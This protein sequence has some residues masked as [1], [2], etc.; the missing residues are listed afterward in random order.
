MSDEARRDGMPN[1]VVMLGPAGGGAEI[2]RRAKVAVEREWDSWVRQALALNPEAQG[3]PGTPATPGFPVIQW[4]C[5]PAL[6][7]GY[8]AQWARVRDLLDARRRVRDFSD[9]SRWERRTLCSLSPRWPAEDSPDGL[10][11][12][13]KDTLSAVNWVK[14]RWRRIQNQDGFASTSSIASAGYRRDVADRLGDPE[15]AAAVSE[16][17][18]AARQVRDERETPVPGLPD[19][20]ADPGRWLVRSAG[21][22][23]Y[24][25]RWQAESLARETKKELDALRPAVVRGAAAARHLAKIMEG[26][27]VAPPASYLAVMVQD[28]DGMGMFLSGARTN[29]AGVQLD[30]GPAAHVAISA[31][32]RRLAAAHRRK[33]ASPDLLGVPVYAGGD[34]LLAFVPAASALA[35]A[36]ACHDLIPPDL[37]TASTAVLFFH[38]HAGL[39]AAM[40]RAR[41]M[42]DQ[43]KA[44][45]PG[46]HALAVG[47]MRRSGASEFSIQPWAVPAIPGAPGGPAASSTAG[48]LGLFAVDRAHPLS[49]RLVTDLERDAGELSRLSVRE[50][51]YRAELARLVGR[52]IRKAGG[53]TEDGTRP[54]AAQAPSGIQAATRQDVAA[55]AAGEAADALWRLGQQEYTPRDAATPDGPRPARAARI[56][57]FLRQEAR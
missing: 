7:G 43:A 13:E 23:I 15:V 10:K 20:R 18:G 30:V 47:Y 44:A 45:V 2:A 50:D 39:Q 35:A 12:Y 51:I 31:A 49:P 16:L 27:G 38:Y 42:L 41:E 54:A 8:L 3:G 28:L 25:D 32:L 46:K 1:R 22:W 14:R 40:S 29:A 21:P 5:V 4:V 9:V 36:Q 34:D 55:Q 56:G 57:V 19:L 37:P 24:E 11:E 52:H 6:P 17:M 26:H 48:L 53:S 33:L